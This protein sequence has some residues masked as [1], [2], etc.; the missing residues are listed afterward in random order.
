RVSCAARHRLVAPFP[1]RR[2]SDL[3]LEQGGDVP[4]DVF[5]CGGVAGRR[6]AVVAGGPGQVEPVGLVQRGHVH[7]QEQRLLGGGGRD[8]VDR[9]RHLVLEGGGVGDAEGGLPVAFGEQAGQHRA[10]R[11]E[12]V[13]E[14]GAAHARGVVADAGERG[15]Q[16]GGVEG[17]GALVGGGAAGE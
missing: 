3:R 12:P 1:T 5:E 2:S 16:V 7:Q 17:P 15:G 11:G 13:E 4:V 6:V 10:E 14:A 9:A 8:D